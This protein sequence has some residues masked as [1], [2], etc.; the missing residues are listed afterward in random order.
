VIVGGLLRPGAVTAIGS[1]PSTDPAEA[2]ALV[3]RTLPDLPAAP[4]LPK[5]S[6]AEGMLAQVTCCIPGVSTTPDG[7]LRVD[8]DELEEPPAINGLDEEAWRGTLAFLDGVTHRRGPVKLQLAGPI[9]VAVGLIKAGAEVAPALSTAATAVAGT[10]RALV[11]EAGLRA[12]GAPLVVFLD[13]PGLV[14]LAE[15][16]F[17]ID[18]DD[19]VDLL[20]GALAALGHEVVTGVH[21]CGAT[22]WS[23]VLQAGPDILSLPVDLVPTL[24][25]SATAGFLDRGGW[26]AW[27]VVPTDRPVGDRGD[28]LWR[29][30]KDAWA[31]LT[32]GGCDPLRL[33]RQAV[34]TPACGLAGHGPAQAQHILALTARLGERL[35]EH[36]A[37]NQSRRSG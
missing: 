21:C 13:E 24:D 28:A 36:T 35:R 15:P 1:L 31:D 10:G 17:P 32:E 20:S 9:T 4:Q 26:I 16:E 23:L 27:G 14:A 34:L 12:P 2:S 37:A 30:L 33:R 29:S 19:A 3:L 18:L 22:D 7:A 5:R 25:P 11:R 8:D 6:A